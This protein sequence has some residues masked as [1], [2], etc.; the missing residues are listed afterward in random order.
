MH[1][2]PCE[3]LARHAW[4]LHVSLHRFPHVPQLNPPCPAGSSSP[5]LTTNGGSFG[6]VSLSPFHHYLRLLLS[7]PHPQPHPLCFPPSLHLPHL[8]HIFI[9]EQWRIII[10]IIII[11]LPLCW[12][13]CWLCPRSSDRFSDAALRI[14]LRPHLVHAKKKVQPKAT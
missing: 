10:I 12:C 11:P 9:S 5:P 2:D 13:P 1:S 7:L 4:S 6:A 3:L 8:H 14:A